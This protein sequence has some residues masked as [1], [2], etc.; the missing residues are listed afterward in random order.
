MNILNNP[1]RKTKKRQPYILEQL[2]NLKKNIT[3]Q[4]MI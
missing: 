2:M 3:Y 4:N 1:L